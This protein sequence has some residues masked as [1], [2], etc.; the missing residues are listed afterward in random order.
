LAMAHDDPHVVEFAIRSPY[1]T[2][3]QLNNLIERSKYG[4]LRNEA[5]LE[6]QKR[7]DEE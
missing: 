2:K 3:E 6:L 5:Y 4:W 7:I 1:I